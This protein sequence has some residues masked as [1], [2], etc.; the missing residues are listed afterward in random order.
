MKPT[1]TKQTELLPMEPKPQGV[2]VFPSLSAIRWTRRERLM[3]RKL[4]APSELKGFAK[5]PLFSRRVKA[6]LFT[7][8]NGGCKK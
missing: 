5:P 3:L 4:Y 6:A 2:T 1:Q 8:L 7:H